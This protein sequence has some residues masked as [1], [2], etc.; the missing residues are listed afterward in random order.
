MTDLWHGTSGPRDAKIVI[1][2]EAWGAAEEAAHAPFVGGS[3]QELNRLLSEAGVSRDS[4][5]CT[6][7]VSARPPNNEMWRFF[8][9]AKGNP[10]PPLRGLHPA[11][12]AREGL[13]TLYAQL[14]TIKPELLIAAGNYPLWA[15]SHTTG[16]RTSAESEGRRVPSGIESWR[17]SMWYTDVSE[18]ERTKLLPIIHPAAIMREWYKRPAC[19]HDL[20]TRIPQALA[21]DWRPTTPPII[22]APPTYDQAVSTFREWLALAN[23]GPFRLVCDIETARGLMTCIGFASSENF[24]MVIPFIRLE[25]VAFDSFWTLEQEHVLISLMR[26]IFQHPNIQIEGQN[27]LYDIQYIAAFLGVVPRLDFDTMLAHH[28]LFPGTP[29]GLDY[30]SSLYCRYHWYWK[31]DGKEWDTKDDLIGHLQYNGL[32]GIRTYEVAT[33]LRKLIV[34]MG[35]A[36]QWKSEC[37]KNDLALRM[38][39]RGIRIDQQ[40]RANLALQLNTARE[41]YAA[42]FERMIPQAI[43]ETNGGVKWWDSPFQQRDIF[44]EQFGMRL[45]THRKTG[46]PTFG[47]DAI[48][49]L[50]QRHPEFT[51]LFERLREY[52]S[53]GVFYNTFVKAPLEFNGRMVCMFNTSGTETFRWSSSKNAFNRGTNLQNIPAGTED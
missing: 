5:F 15:L 43:S 18:I 51:K 16:A 10:N 7:V 31:E 23:A 19:K 27:F 17:G 24:A 4:V 34:D 45:P 38:M 30:L 28:L 40:R 3:G 47:K 35:Q 41:Q 8:E 21:N 44:S 1:V 9:I 39:L 53:L 50:I 25:G 26:E 48:T 11:E 52:R 33:V 46:N 12:R 37:A 36:E 6:N 29:K 20:S 32:D 14:N 42:W 13:R 49:T 2:G 22:L